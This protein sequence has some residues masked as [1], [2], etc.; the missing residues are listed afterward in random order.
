MNYV[1]VS[2]LNKDILNNLH[3]IPRDIDLVVG[4][5]R[6]G[7][8]PATLIALYLNKSLSDLDSFI[9]GKVY[10]HGTTKNISV[11][12]ESMKDVKKALIVEDSSNTGVSLRNAKERLRNIGENIELMYM[13]A[14]VTK[15]TKS[16]VDISCREI[17]T[18]RIFEWNFIH[19]CMLQQ[20][21]VDIDGVLCLD[22]TPEENDDGIKYRGFIKNAKPKLIPTAK[23]GWIVTSR[24]EKYRKDTEEWLKNYNIQYDHLCMMDVKSAEERRKLGNHAAF[25]AFVYKKAKDTT[26]FIESEQKQAEE[27]ARLT[28][29]QVLCVNNSQYQSESIKIWFI[30]KMKEILKKFAVKILPQPLIKKIKAVVHRKN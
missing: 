24:L 6:S 26:F 18:P 12:E 10:S 23:I 4:V 21:C 5:P 15:E 14:Y 19:H 7:M 25:K 30:W 2:K 28:G 16:L 17:A 3:K 22:P 29:K 11:L 1:S 9:E 20:A 13:A 8:L 27:I